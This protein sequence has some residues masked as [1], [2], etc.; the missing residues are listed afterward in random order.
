M[1]VDEKILRLQLWDTAG[2][3]RF[4]SLIPSYIKDS[5]FAIVVY[6]VTSKSSFESVS[7]WI[8]D[9][10]SIRGDDV[11]IIL[12]GNKIDDADKREVTTDEGQKLAVE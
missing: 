4:R 1:F 3:E 6:D 12:V 5:S 9:S 2:Q 10:K 8:E 11:S 7:K